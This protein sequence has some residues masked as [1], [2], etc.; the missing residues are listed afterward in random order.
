M[1][2]E[3]LAGGSGLQGERR[4][5]LA[6]IL[7]QAAEPLEGESD[8]PLDYQAW[9]EEK[10]ARFTQSAL[11]RRFSEKGREVSLIGVGRLFKSRPVWFPPGEE[12]LGVA[13]KRYALD[14]GLV[15]AYDTEY[16]AR[17]RRN[18]ILS[19]QV[20][21][22]EPRGL[23]W[24]EFIIHVRDGD[25]LTLDEIIDATRLHLR[26]KPRSLATAG[27]LVVSHFGAAE[28]S[29]L[30]GRENLAGFLQLIRKVPVTLS[31]AK[32]SL[33]ISNRAQQCRLRIMD[34]FLLAPD[35]GKGLKKL[36]DTVGI[37]KVDLPAGAIEDMAALRETNREL[38]EEYGIND[39]RITLAY[40][41][42]MIDVVQRELRL[43]KMPLTVGGIAT[44]A[45][46]S[47][48]SEAD[49]LDAFGLDKRTRH[50]RKAEIVPGR[51]REW[52][53]GPFKDGFCGG[54]NNATPGVVRVEDGRVVFDIDFISAYPTAAATVP[55][56]DWSDL[57]KLQDMPDLRTIRGA[58]GAYLT[59]V[60]L[61]YT[62]FRFPEGTKRPCIPVRVGKYGLIYPWR[63]QQ[64]V[65]A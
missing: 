15:L 33:R 37:R 28:W 29:A 23:R 38:F 16:Q 44:K 35:N 17:E 55:R 22:Y 11:A 43:E 26:V 4:L 46:V 60:T 59:P 25:R 36:G 48:M 40:L 62:R 31:W 61:A 64:I 51:V 7:Q 3:L 50:R 19:Y 30:E 5:N 49:Y 1:S 9:P 45:F 32:T 54:L 8:G 2:V 53:D 42:H 56:L 39:S 6:Q 21:A 58:Q 34:T 27:V 63:C 10:P 24:C 47:S 65:L 20:C 12:A 52:A 13:A 18:E 57:A 41:I 14:A